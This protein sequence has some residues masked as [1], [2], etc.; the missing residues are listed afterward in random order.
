VGS[1]R[2]DRTFPGQASELGK[3]GY[4][5]TPQAPNEHPRPLRVGG[6]IPQTALLPIVTR[7]YSFG[8]R[9]F[10]AYSPEITSATEDPVLRTSNG[11]DRRDCFQYRSAGT[12]AQAPPA[13][14][15]ER[16]GRRGSQA[17]WLPAL[18]LPA[19]VP[20][21]YGP[22]AESPASDLLWR[23]AAGTALW[24]FNSVSWVQLGGKV[25]WAGLRGCGCGA[26]T[27]GQQRVLT[28]T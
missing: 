22:C 16:H 13:M 27:A 20:V 9:V 24:G 8:R 7:R 10:A 19:A 14:L 25:I 2:P 28:I 6:A 17:T 15:A 21:G 18:P 26:G 12:R 1:T 5:N 23:L 4:V 11:P 3:S